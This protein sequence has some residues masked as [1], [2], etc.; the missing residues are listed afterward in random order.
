[1]NARH[2]L[3]TILTAA[4]LGLT[5][6]TGAPSND[7]PAT[8]TVTETADTTTA[9]DPAPAP[10]SDDTT[11]AIVDYSWA[12]QTE[13]DKDAMCFGLALYGTSWGAKQMRIGA[14]D[15]SVDWDRAA[16]LVQQKCAQR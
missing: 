12:Q 7:S 8:S 2:A 5:A 4:A 9:P 15:E 13:D 14:G 11:Q 10:A 6:C 1:M 3:A 16:V